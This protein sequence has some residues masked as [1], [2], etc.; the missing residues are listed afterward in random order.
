MFSTLDTFTKSIIYRANIFNY[1]NEFIKDF[2]KGQKVVD[3][4]QF[5]TSSFKFSKDNIGKFLSF[6]N[7]PVKDQLQNFNTLTELLHDQDEDK[8]APIHK[9]SK[10]VIQFLL[11]VLKNSFELFVNTEK[12]RIN[13]QSSW[14]VDQISSSKQESE[15]I[16]CNITY[17]LLFLDGLIMNNIELAAVF[18]LLS[19]DVGVEIKPLLFE[20]I[21]YSKIPNTSKEIASHILSSILIFTSTSESNFQRLIEWSINYNESVDRKRDNAFTSNLCLILSNEV[22]L[23][24][25]INTFKTKRPVNELI[26]IMTKDYSINSVYEALFCIWSISNSD[27]HKNLFE[28]RDLALVEKTIQVI[29]TNK[30]E[31]IVRIGCLL[32]KNL[33]LSESTLEILIDFQF[34]KTVK[35]LLSNK[36]TDELIK[37][38]LIAISDFLEK[39]NKFVK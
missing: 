36:W 13:L 1:D 8:K 2:I 31:K 39:N 37:E 34:I 18:D 22:A 6:I 35:N 30:V 23:D 16:N 21:D 20:I 7:N 29:K 32:V 15:A 28:N 10:I 26:N 5:K 14:S 24:I 3:E 33:L 38:E 27:K 12:E 19:I 17:S 9:E 25:F 11:D 4:K